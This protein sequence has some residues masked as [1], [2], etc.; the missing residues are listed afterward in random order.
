MSA[1]DQNVTKSD[2]VVKDGQQPPCLCAAGVNCTQKL[3]CKCRSFE[4][5]SKRCV[6]FLG[7]HD[8]ELLRNLHGSQ[9]HVRRQFIRTFVLLHSKTQS[10]VDNNPAGDVTNKTARAKVPTTR[11][12]GSHLDYNYRGKKLCRPVFMHITNI[13]KDMITSAKKEV[14]KSNVTVAPV[15]RKVKRISGKRKRK[16]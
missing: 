10:Q 5:S 2:A 9:Q 15:L 14:K 13:G 1:M 7:S 3:I 8:L 16:L 6:D 12:R 4:G 11:Q